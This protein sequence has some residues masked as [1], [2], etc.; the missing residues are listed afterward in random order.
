MNDDPAK[1]AGYEATL[2]RQEAQWE[3]Q[4]NLILNS[5]RAAVDIGIGALKTAV[6]INAGSLVA[7]LAL[8]GQLWDKDKGHLLLAHIFGAS[9]PFVWGLLF[10]GIAFIIA[11]LYQSI[12]TKAEWDKLT[13]LASGQEKPPPKMK[14]VRCCMRAFQ[15]PMVLL[16][17]AS[18]VEFAQGMLS[19]VH[20]FQTSM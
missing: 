6:L 12:L 3:A 4:F 20:V 14:M 11:Y 9:V 5:D 18:F 10:V 8:T 17:I 2:R 1:L 16:A 7:L 13:L 15:I 19:V